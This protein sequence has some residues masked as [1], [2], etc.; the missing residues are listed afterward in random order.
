[1]KQRK[2]CMYSSSNLGAQKS[3]FYAR[4]LNL[5]VPCALGVQFKMERRRKAMRRKLL[6]LAAA[7]SFAVPIAASAQSAWDSATF[8]HDAPPAAWERIDFLQTRI[9]HGRADGS[10]NEHEGIRAQADLH[11]IRDLAAQMRERDGGSLNATDETYVQ[12]RLDNLSRQI[13][14]DRHN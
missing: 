12:G 9:D 7:V 5:Q 11:Q 8:W 2:H 1:M 13:R 4:R 14:W 10:L 6:I 3:D